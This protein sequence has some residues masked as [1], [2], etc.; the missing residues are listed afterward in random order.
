METLIGVIIIGIVGFSLFRAFTT[1]I[2]VFGTIKIKNAATNLANEQMEVIKN[3]S[4]SVIGTMGGIPS[5][6]IAP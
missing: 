2:D 6:V 1:L 5:G 4:Y 3:M